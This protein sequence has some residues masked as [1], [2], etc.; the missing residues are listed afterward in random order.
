MISIIL[1]YCNTFAMNQRT[2]QTRALREE[3]LITVIFL[4]RIFPYLG[5]IIRFTLKITVFGPTTV[6]HG[7]E[8]FRIWALFVQ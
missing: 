3:C 8:K 6:K 7:P 1:Q 2:H 5:H 4:V